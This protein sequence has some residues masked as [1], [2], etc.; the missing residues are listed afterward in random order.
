MH[1]VLKANVCSTE[2]STLN[3]SVYTYLAGIPFQ[4]SYKKV[5]LAVSKASKTEFKAA[6][7]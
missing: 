4:F 3:V 5:I 2:Q 6:Q 7:V 1:A